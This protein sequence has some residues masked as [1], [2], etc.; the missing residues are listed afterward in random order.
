VAG[1]SADE[2]R[3]WSEY[4]AW[5]RGAIPNQYELTEA[6]AWE[7]LQRAVIGPTL[8]ALEPAADQLA[9]ADDPSTGGW[10]EEL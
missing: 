9:D 4:L 6:R 3:A 1:L 5:T 7:R 8:D 2:Q 10:P